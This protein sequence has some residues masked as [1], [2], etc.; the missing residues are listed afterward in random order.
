LTILLLTIGLL[1]FVL[2]ALG[3]FKM[4][5]IGGIKLAKVA[6]PRLFLGVIILFMLFALSR[7]VYR[8][9][10]VTRVKGRP[11]SFDFDPLTSELLSSEDVERETLDLLRLGIIPSFLKRI[12]DALVF[13]L[14][15]VLIVA[16]L[17]AVAFQLGNV[18][19][20]VFVDAMMGDRPMQGLAAL[21]VVV[22]CAIVLRACSCL[23]IAF[24]P[25]RDRHEQWH[26]LV[27][28][29]LQKRRFAKLLKRYTEDVEALL[30]QRKPILSDPEKRRDFFKALEMQSAEIGVEYLECGGFEPLSNVKYAY[31]MDDIECGL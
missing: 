11:V 21:V 13:I 7:G 25:R 4:P 10:N 5:E 28:R 26:R 19:A 22:G 6:Q 8:H 24:A 29:P 15:A 16:L 18:F 17:F 9:I 1:T 23:V 31:D 2:F 3:E 27:E 12:F 30:N 20:G 14:S